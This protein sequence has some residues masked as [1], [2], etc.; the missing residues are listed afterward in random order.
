MQN[1]L[2]FLDLVV[3]ERVQGDTVM[4]TFFGEIGSSFFDTAA[5]MG[6]MQVKGLVL[7]KSGIGRSVVNRTENG[8]RILQ[9][10]E[11]KAGELLDELDHAIMK[12]IASGVNEFNKIQD[13]LSIRSED[14]AYRF[15]KITKQGYVGYN[16]RNAKTYFALTENG[17]KLTG[18]VPKIK[19]TS[20]SSPATGA[21]MGETKKET[22][23]NPQKGVE[24]VMGTEDATKHLPTAKEPVDIKKKQAEL[25][26]FRTLRIVAVIIIIVGIAYIAARYLGYLK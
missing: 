25:Q 20:T 11:A 15:Y 4:E 22:P 23:K 18:V 26:M 5:L 24:L 21:G 9:Q 13:Q 16:I 8:E 1:D 2:T 14:L 10:A 6:T 3:L 7:I 19:T 12:T 17:F